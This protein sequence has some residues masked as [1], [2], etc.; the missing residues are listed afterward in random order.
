MPAR[1][2]TGVAAHLGTLDG[3]V[4]ARDPEFGDLGDTYAI[5]QPVGRTGVCWDC[6]DAHAAA[7]T[8]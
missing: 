5:L 1:T 8:V 4:A 6:D 3:D 7:G 2:T